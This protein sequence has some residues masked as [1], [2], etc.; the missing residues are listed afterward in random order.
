M[1]LTGASC[2]Y[3]VDTI[4]A[5]RVF[6]DSLTRKKLWDQTMEPVKMKSAGNKTTKTVS[7]SKSSLWGRAGEKGKEHAQN[8]LF[9]GK[10]SNEWKKDTLPKN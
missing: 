8:P 3:H 5:E 7:F 6:S 9:A 10:Q 1:L 2:L 4:S